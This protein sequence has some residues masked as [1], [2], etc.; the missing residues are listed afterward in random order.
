M[1]R[2]LCAR[3]PAAR[4]VY[5]TA[6]AAFGAG[7]S[8]LCFDG[9]D[10][11]LRPT[12]VQQPAIVATSIAAFAAFAEALGLPQWSL[13]SA[14]HPLPVAAVAGHSVG[15]CSAVIATGA[16]SLQDG[17]ALVADRGRF[18]AQ[19]AREKPGAMAAVLGLEPQVVERTVE[20]VRAG[21][22]GSYLSVANVNSPGQ[23]VVAG[24]LISVDALR[25]AAAGAGA[26]RVVP[27]GVSGA[28]HSVAMLPARD[29]MRDR[30]LAVELSDPAVPVLSNLDGR[31]LTTAAALREELADHI[32]GPVQWLRGVRELEAM[33][34]THMVEY[35]HGNVLTGMLRRTVK[36]IA[37]Y[38]VADADSAT[39]V[40]KELSDA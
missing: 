9:P 31:P 34:V 17:V 21:I 24:D 29:A 33:G 8:V 19:A 14:P 23:V 4:R 28:F 12:H 15:L 13:S 30:L 20:Q 37:L 1:G 5:E 18:M 25:Q 22:P 27:L 40:A 35:G 2:D 10:E 32:A 36:G 26:R 7:L 3:S 39:Q 38:N 6:D 11:A 16:M